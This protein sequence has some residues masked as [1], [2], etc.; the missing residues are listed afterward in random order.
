M[1]GVMSGTSLDGIDLAYVSLTLNNDQWRYEF[2]KTATIAYS[3]SWQARLAQSVSL[4]EQQL[5]SLDR[6][7]TQLLV[8]VI[9]SFVLKNKIKE[10][11][12][13]CSHG[14]TVLHQPH[15]GVTLQIGNNANLA[16][17]IS[18]LLV[19][20]F[21]VADVA[22]GG[23]GAPLVPIGD[24]L[25][26]GTYNY[27]VNL[28]GFAN[29]SIESP[30]GRIAYD[31]CPVNVL[32]NRYANMLG[33]PYDDHGAFAQS[34]ILLPGLLNELNAL[35]YYSKGA[36]KSLGMEWVLSEAL[37]IIES[38]QANPKDILCTLVEHMAIQITTRLRET[39]TVL[40]TG[41]GAFNSY[42]IARMR[43]HKTA[44]Y[45][46]PDHDLVNYK[47]ALIFALLGVL[48]LRDEPNCLATV[49]G[50]KR[51]HSSGNIFTVE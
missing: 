4:P 24:R 31:L 37:P 5:S 45:Q 32:L 14:H 1:I 7:Y 47:E 29:M 40:L 33:A 44:D 42:L 2:I 10:I 18:A 11:D 22:L 46:V 21:R 38:Y 9:N 35:P 20:D 27:C 39:A 50:A 41:G 48:K 15:K 12:A 26:F 8:Q 30:Y 28:G 19:C 43:A 34:G 23:Q 17:G 36:P 13:V 6:D 49:T 16:K 3:E 25:L 51:D